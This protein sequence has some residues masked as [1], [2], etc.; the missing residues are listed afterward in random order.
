[1]GTNNLLERVL[2]GASFKDSLTEATGTVD[3]LKLITDIKDIAVTTTAMGG[4]TG[5]VIAVNGAFELVYFNGIFNFRTSS[6]NA[7]MMIEESMIQTIKI[8]G[9]SVQLRL[10]NKDLITFTITRRIVK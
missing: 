3:D 7:Y 4:Q 2:G 10:R 6:G 5:L 9:L 8:S 1:M